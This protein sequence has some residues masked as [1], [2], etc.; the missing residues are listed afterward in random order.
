[1]TTLRKGDVA[2]LEAAGRTGEDIDLLRSYLKGRGSTVGS[3]EVS[4]DACGRS[5]ETLRAVIAMIECLD[6]QDP[7]LSMLY[8]AQDRLCAVHRLPS[9]GPGRSLKPKG[10]VPLDDVPERQRQQVMKSA[11]SPETCT[12]RL[13]TLRAV[14]GAARRAGLPEEFG[15]P[16]LAAY[17]EELEEGGSAA[18]TI[19]E[20]MSRCA[21]LSQLFGCGPYLLKKIRA[22]EHSARRRAREEESRMKR[23]F[24]EHPVSPMDY[25]RIAG[26][27]SGQAH[28]CTSGRE[29]MHDLFI[30]AG[31]CSY[32]SWSPD[33]VSDIRALVVGKNIFRTGHGWQPR[34]RSQ[35]TGVD[36]TLPALPDAVTPYLDD[37]ILLG[38][39][40]GLAGENLDRLYHR[41]VTMQSPLF[42]TI[43]LA[44]SYSRNDIW[45]MLKDETGHGPHASRKAMADHCAE[46]GLSSEV[47]A[48]VVGHRS[49]VS[50]K[51]DYE[52]NAAMI[53]RSQTQEKIA[54]L[55]RQLLAEEETFRTPSGRLIDLAKINR[56]LRRYRSAA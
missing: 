16:A 28:A 44:E 9:A 43:G 56:A 41:R 1:M 23:K 21:C 42:S 22:D 5:L 15:R 3:P 54:Q 20:Y 30:K 55:R 11:M 17:M 26:E 36:R 6:R 37:L 48:A 38:A 45:Q 34:F 47:A 46:A 27:L 49:E 18:S 33:R 53:R 35:K 39:D 19:R 51:D 14:Y 40:P 7:D 24:R 50:I 8:A 4:I 29:D 52:V 32:L 25:E 2:R 12:G 13:S 10:M 31:L